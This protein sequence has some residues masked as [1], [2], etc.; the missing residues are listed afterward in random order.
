LDCNCTCN[1]FLHLT[2]EVLEFC[3]HCSSRLTRTL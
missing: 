1:H 2:L 3:P